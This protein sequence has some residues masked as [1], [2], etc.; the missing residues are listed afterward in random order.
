MATCMVIV[1]VTVIVAVIVT[2][3]VT[4]LL[5]CT[6]AGVSITPLTF[7]PAYDFTLCA[8]QSP[9]QMKS[10]TADVMRLNGWQMGNTVRGVLLLTT[11]AAAS[12]PGG[13]EECQ[14]RECPPLEEPAVPTTASK[15]RHR[16]SAP[17]VLLCPHCAAV[18]RMCCCA[19]TV[20]LLIR[21]CS[22]LW[23]HPC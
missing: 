14:G 15:P 8:V 16:C 11:G 19:P 17:T 23:Q 12:K 10:F 1:I 6:D 22:C 4:V 5:Q 3:T 7:L 2:V 21:A 18:H 9:W 20:Q 13:I